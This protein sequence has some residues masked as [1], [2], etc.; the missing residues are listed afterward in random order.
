[1][2]ATIAHETDVG[3]F[4]FNTG[5]SLNVFCM[6]VPLGVPDLFDNETV[7]TFQ[8]SGGLSC[9]LAVDPIKMAEK[10]CP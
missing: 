1:M 9:A 5:L 2:A 7:V 10:V 8:I 6:G 4:R 3:A